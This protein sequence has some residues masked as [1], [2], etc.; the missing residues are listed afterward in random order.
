MLEQ[1]I[2]IIKV[3]PQSIK[4]NP[5]AGITEYKV[6][7]RNTVEILRI[8]DNNKDPKYKKGDGQWPDQ[9]FK[10]ILLNT[11][12]IEKVINGFVVES[13][14]IAR[15][16]DRLISNTFTIAYQFEIDRFREAHPISEELLIKLLYHEISEIVLEQSM[17][18]PITT[19]RS[20]IPEPNYLYT[21]ID[22]SIECS[23]CHSQFPY[24]QL[25]SDAISLGCDE[26][27]SNTICPVCGNW[28]CCDI[29]FE[30]VD[31]AG[32]IMAAGLIR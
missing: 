20:M 1:P 19:V 26:A 21:H 9:D 5:D 11:W 7:G 17:S 16:K 25:K 2:F 28:D 24:Q 4:P 3:N 10:R 18:R 12:R 32:N 23:S 27:W 29:S 6:V 22:Q 30:H 8:V 14:V 31:H 13:E 15:G